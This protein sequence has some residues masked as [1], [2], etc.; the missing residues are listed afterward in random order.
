MADIRLHVTPGGTTEQIL[1]NGVDIAD[2]CVGYTLRAHVGEMPHLEVDMI[3][4]HPAEVDGDAEV[5]V[6]PDTVEA[7]IALGWTPPE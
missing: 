6:P 1:V 7:L 4:L 2:A 3:V 5:T